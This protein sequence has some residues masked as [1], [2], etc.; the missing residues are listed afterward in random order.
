LGYE[1]EAALYGGL[2]GEI[3]QA[4]LHEYFT[5]SGRL[6]IDTQTGYVI[7]LHFGLWRDKEKLTAGLLNRLK[8]DGYR[9]K[10]GFVGAPLIC[11]V[12][13]ENGMGRW[14]EH[15]L[16]QEGF[17]GWLHCVKLGATTI[18]ERWNSV[19]ADGS[20]SGT[21]MNSLNHYAYGSVVSYIARY[22]A[23]LRPLSPGW[24]RALIA[25]QYSLALQHA[26]CVFD[27][28]HGRYSVSWRIDKDGTVTLRCAVPFNC[29]AVLRLPGYAQG[30]LSIGPGPFELS[31]SLP[32]SLFTLYAW[33][34]PL[35][36][37]AGDKRAMDI[38]GE[39]IPAAHAMAAG[40]DIEALSRT[41][42]ELGSN[43]WFG[44]APAAVNKAAERLFRLKPEWAE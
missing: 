12:L 27:S 5:P 11:E 23:G 22:V 6:S 38:L 42:A 25:P 19:L 35:E 4:V 32:D 44:C 30:E 3:R 20:I 40:D 2:A 21:G 29:K 16:L 37:Y 13:A 10:C 33:D 15:L 43:P 9:I 31:Y 24:R 18:W 26:D 39:L 34:T 1:R 14:A 17:P 41:L 8:K 36:K 28:P 7:A